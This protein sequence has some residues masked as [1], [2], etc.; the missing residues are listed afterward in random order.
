MKKILSLVMAVVLSCTFANLRADELT[1]ADGTTYN[2]GRFVPLYGNY[3]DQYQHVQILYPSTQLSLMNGKQ[4][5][6]LTF[7]LKT[8]PILSF[9]EV[10][11]LQGR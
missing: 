1:V 10:P 4:I 6:S 5:K 7:Y 11:L 8:K 2:N 9:G 3:D